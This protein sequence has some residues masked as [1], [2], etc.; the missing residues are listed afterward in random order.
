MSFINSSDRGQWWTFFFI[1]HSAQNAVHGSISNREDHLSFDH[2]STLS[3]RC[4]TQVWGPRFD[5][6]G[7]GCTTVHNSSGRPGGQEGIRVTFFFPV[8]TDLHQVSMKKQNNQQETMT[9]RRIDSLIT[10]QFFA[11]CLFLVLRAETVWIHSTHPPFQIPLWSFR[12][13]NPRCE[14]H[15]ILH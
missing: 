2:S 7:G 4:S 11:L 14:R 5:L 13:K 9:S 8:I 6:G 1:V 10:S 12:P 15:T 3:Q